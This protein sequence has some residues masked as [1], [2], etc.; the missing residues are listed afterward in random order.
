MWKLLFVG[1]AA[2]FVLY[3]L[4]CF[5]ILP[6]RNTLANDVIFASNLLISNTLSLLSQLVE[7]M[8]ISLFYAAL[9]LLIYHYGE[10]RSANAFVVFTAVTV[11][12][13]L[14]NTA[15]S[16]IYEGSIPS[17]WAWD[18]VNVLFYTALELLQLF[19]IFLIVKGIIC[20]YTEIRDIRARAAE[21]AVLGADVRIEE[22]YPFKNVYDKSNCLQRSALI[23]A[24]VTV[25]AKGVG[26]LVSDVWL[27]LLYGLPEDPVTWI[28][29]I[30][31]YVIKVILGAVVYFV[32]VYTMNPLTRL[33]K[34]K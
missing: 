24:I 5:I 10:K 6:V 1:G 3:S 30:I 27:M 25:I 18:V 16:W 33:D 4:N 12:K 7:V 34:T 17:T 15:V 14:A 11:Y 13:Y 31:S 21:K 26:S 20:R 32:T 2:L 22:A 28:M 8:A 23:C 29:M 19:V 9:L